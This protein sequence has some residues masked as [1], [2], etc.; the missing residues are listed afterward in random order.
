MKIL[1]TG[2]HIT[3]ALAVAD[4][5]SA[6][7]IEIAIVGR[8]HSYKVGSETM[9][10]KLIKSRNIKLIHLDAGRFSRNFS[11]Q[12]LV[13]LLKIP[14]GFINALG[15]V[16]KEHPSSIL[17]FGGYLG[18]PIAVAGWILRI[19]VYTHEQVMVPGV[20]NRI[21]SHFAKQV[22]ISF[23]ESAGYFPKNK[24]L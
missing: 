23:R 9:E 15:I 7:G 22:F 13:H 8:A 11:I 4:E 5:C 18:L 3:P 19:P 2:G 10:S 12:S 24:T 1:L 17:S 6:R 20:T 16:K 14:T 21:I